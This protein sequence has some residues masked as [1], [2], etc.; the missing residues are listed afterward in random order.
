MNEG[1]Q[2]PFLHTNTHTNFPS[3]TPEF[4]APE[5]YEECYTERVD[6]YA[7]GMT[8]LEMV[9]KEYPYQEC[10]NAAQIYRKVLRVCCRWRAERERREEEGGA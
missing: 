2:R 10:S 1:A 5:L 3:G 9:S 4:M 6:I 8:V 7:F